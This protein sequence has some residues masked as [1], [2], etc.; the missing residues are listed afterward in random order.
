M[1]RFLQLSRQQNRHITKLLT[2]CPLRFNNTI[3]REM[4]RL[5]TATIKTN[6]TEKRIAMILFF[7]LL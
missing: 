3:I 4:H 7:R 5:Y 6:I 1:I 2:A